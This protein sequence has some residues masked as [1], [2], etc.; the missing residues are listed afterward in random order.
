MQGIAGRTDGAV[1]RGVLAVASATNIQLFSLFDLSGNARA[2]AATETLKINSIT[3]STHLAST[4]EVLTSATNSTIIKFETVAA[5]P[6]AS[7]FN[8]G[9][10]CSVGKLPGVKGPI[11]Q[12]YLQLDGEILQPVGS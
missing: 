7:Q 4:L 3:G 9:R 8:A 11:S 12:T 5:G 1:V 10:F 2:L 6:F